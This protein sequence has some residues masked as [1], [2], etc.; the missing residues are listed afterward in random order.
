MVRGATEEI[1]VHQAMD[2]RGRKVFLAHLD[3]QYKLEPEAPLDHMETLGFL[4]NQETKVIPF[5]KGY[6]TI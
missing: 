6:L 2:R 5:L 4:A 1:W 3:C